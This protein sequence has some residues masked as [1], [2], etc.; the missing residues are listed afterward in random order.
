MTTLINVVNAKSDGLSKGSASE[1][2]NGS[3]EWVDLAEAVSSLLISGLSL[4]D[5]TDLSNEDTIIEALGKAQAQLINIRNSKRV[6]QT[7]EDMNLSTTAQINDYALV[8]STGDVYQRKTVNTVDSWVNVGS[9]VLNQLLTAIASEKDSR[10]KLILDDSLNALRVM[11][12]DYFELMFMDQNKFS[13]P[14]LIDISNSTDQELVVVG[15]DGFIVGIISLEGVNSLALAKAYTDTQAATT[16]TAAK[17]YADSVASSV[18]ISAN[19][20]L[21]IGTPLCSFIGKPLLINVCSLM[22]QRA[23]QTKGRNLIASISATSNPYTISSRDLLYIPDLSL[24][25]NGFITVRDTRYA[26]YTRIPYTAITPATTNKSGVSPKVLM[27]GDS[28]TNREL[29]DIIKNQLTGYSYNPTF[30]GTLNTSAIGEISTVGSG[31]LAEAREGWKVTDYTY[32]V[33][34]RALIVSPGSESTYMTMDKA[35]KK[36]YN[37]FLRAATGSDDASIIRNGYVLDFTDYQNRFSLSS[38]DIIVIQLGTNDIRDRDEPSLTTDYYS[39][40]TL[41]IRR[42]RVAWP[43]AKIIFSLPNTASSATRDAV[44][45]SDYAPLIRN[46][47]Q[48]KYDLADSKIFIAPT[49]ALTSNEVGYSITTDTA[50]VDALTGAYVGT[51]ADEVHPQYASRYA[52]AHTLAA[53]IAAAADNLI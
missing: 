20:P 24:F 53:Y 17:T 13:I 41:L 16:L 11:G 46:L 36:E 4:S 51:L 12:N 19:T 3:L 52:L 10:E 21:F 14:G 33:S 42:L 44:W 32:Q 18:Q 15:T 7:V 37:P 40:M 50:T 1:V 29:V 49:W 34:T 26:T 25:G 48:I 2:L 30:I 27:I 5:S 9:T 8:I 35:T 22:A 43:N 31:S 45:L 28:I 38:P 39:E 23:D 47:F 6:F